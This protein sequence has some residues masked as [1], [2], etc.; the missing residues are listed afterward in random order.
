MK[1]PI[2]KGID[3]QPTNISVLLWYVNTPELI[4]LKDRHQ[5]AM[6]RFLFSLPFTLIPYS[7]RQTS[8]KAILEVTND[9]SLQQL[10]G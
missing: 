3:A 2:G 9:T 1:H 10:T 5:K 6:N 4:L 7:Q 8:A